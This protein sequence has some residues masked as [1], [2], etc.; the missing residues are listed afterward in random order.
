M[1]FRTFDANKHAEQVVPPEYAVNMISQTW[2]DRTMGKKVFQADGDTAQLLHAIAEPMKRWLDTLP[3]GASISGRQLGE[4]FAPELQEFPGF[5]LAFLKVLYTM[6]R[7]GAFD[8]YFS[9]SVVRN[10]YGKPYVNF[11]ARIK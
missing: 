1:T 9:R 6:R 8:G 5:G 2:R 3:A 11:H 4:V 10:R 7:I